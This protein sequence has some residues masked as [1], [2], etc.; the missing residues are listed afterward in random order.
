M[1]NAYDQMICRT[2][3]HLY[4]PVQIVQVYCKV[5]LCINIPVYCKEAT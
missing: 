5:R 3:V 2:Q 4:E 1:R